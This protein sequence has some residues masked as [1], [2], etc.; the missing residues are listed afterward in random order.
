MTGEAIKKEY[1]SYED[2][3]LTPITSVP[4]T[5]N[6]TGGWK[7]FKPVLDKEKCIKCNICWKFCPDVAI[8]ID[9][10]GYPEFD[11]DYCKGCGICAHECRKD[12]ITMILEGD[13]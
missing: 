1:K 3:P 9:E 4:S 6:K 12:A 11:L 5:R 10:E 13:E 7:T 2:L 8:H